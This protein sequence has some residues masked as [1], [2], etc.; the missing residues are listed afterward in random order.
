MV[1]FSCQPQH[2]LNFAVYFIT[3]IE[4]IVIFT[5]HLHF[6]VNCLKRFSFSIGFWS[7]RILL[8]SFKGILN[9]LTF[10]IL[11]QI[12]VCV[13]T[14][15]IIFC[16]Y[17]SKLVSQCCVT[18]P[19]N[20]VACNN[21]PLLLFVNLWVVYVVF[22]SWLDS[23]MPLCLAIGQRNASLD[24]TEI[25]HILGIGRLAELSPGLG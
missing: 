11:L 2:L 24:L 19:L 18:K 22:W 4:Q 12:C 7:T 20:S 13:S 21:N 23:L 5:S 17:L 14:H 8:I 1:A 25:S 6:S 16:S 3:R 10:F 15:V 9:I